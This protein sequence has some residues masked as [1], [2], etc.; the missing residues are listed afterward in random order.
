MKIELLIDSSV[1][2]LSIPANIGFDLN[3]AIDVFI[4]LQK[5]GVKCEIIETCGFEEEKRWKVYEKAI[6]PAVWKRYTVGKVFGTRKHH[7]CF[8][9]K[10]IPALLVYGEGDHPEEV[11]PHEKSGNTY[12]IKDF[13]DR[14]IL[15]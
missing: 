1:T 9:G 12:T 3:W 15:N 6:I 7:G 10:E 8:F 13:L 14:L 4:K 5:R 11:Y 2:A